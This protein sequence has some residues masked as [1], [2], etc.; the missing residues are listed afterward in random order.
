MDLL[1]ACY[2]SVDCRTRVVKFQFPNDPFLEWKNSSAMPKGHFISYLK[3]RKLVSK[4]CVYYLVR[5]NN[6]TIEIPPIQSVSAFLV[7]E[8]QECF[9]R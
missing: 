9:P 1:H 5:V 4:A 7:I 2:A 6:S 8:L 3:A